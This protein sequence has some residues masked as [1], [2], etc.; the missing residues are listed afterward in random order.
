MK[1]K[2]AILN[3]SLRVGVL[4]VTL[5]F[6]LQAMAGAYQV[7]VG[8]AD[9]LR[10]APFFPNPYNT[11][12]IFQGNLGG[13]D[14]GA[15]RI[16]NTGGSDIFLNDLQVRLNPSGGGPGVQNFALWNFGS[17]SGIPDATGLVL[18]PGQ[19]AVFGSTGNY[20]FDTSDYGVL[21]LFAPNGDNCS[22]GPAASTPLCQNNAPLVSFSVNGVTTPKS[23]TGHVLDTGGFDFVYANPC[24]VAGDAPGFCNES[25]QWRFIGTTGVQDPGGGNP[26]PEPASMLLLGSGLVGLAAWRLRKSAKLQA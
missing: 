22:I 11:A 7:F 15:V 16:Q 20:N 21:G 19:N 5:M 8:Y 23:D 14:S 12:D 4:F 10:P 6:P 13:L 2:N 18:H 9:S 24:P 26:V 25:L 3:W 1:K 17:G